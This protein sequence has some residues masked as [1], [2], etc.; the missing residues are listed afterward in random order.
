MKNRWAQ[1][2]VTGL[3]LGLAAL[4]VLTQPLSAPAEAPSA[5]P[6]RT[7]SHGLFNDLQVTRPLAEPTRVVLLL[8][9]TSGADAA[10]ATATAQAMTNAGAMVVR[11]DAPRFL[12]RLAGE[13]GSC[14]FADGALENL[15]H[16][17][18]AIFKLSSYIAPV[19]VGLGDNAALA[20]AV[21]A[22]SAPGTF[23]AAMSVGFCPKLA[24]KLPLCAG[25]GLRSTPSADGV[26][27]VLQPALRL[28]ASWAA[29]QA[30]T[31][32]ACN[33]RVA[34]P[35]VASA[36]H[37]QLVAV[38]S[39][40]EA[41]PAPWLPAFKT[42][43]ANLQIAPNVQAAPP[44]S[45]ADL[46]VI[47]VPTRVE[48]GDRFAVFLSG[49]GGWAG[50]DKDV[51]RAIAASG[52]PVAGFDSLR[53]FWTAR[54]P[55]GLADDLDRLIRYYAARWNR[56]RVMLIGYSQG[57]DVLPFAINRLPAATRA[58]I[59]ST[60]LLGLAQKASFEFRLGNWIGESGDKPVAPEAARLFASNTVCIHGSDEKN[61][62]CPSLAP[63][64]ARVLAMKG[65]H[66]FGGDYERLAAIILAQTATP[67]PAR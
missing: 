24:L 19:I 50:I 28:N 6:P 38:G 27:V 10:A 43:Y 55:Q 2:G 34:Q 57:A 47:E 18:E 53:Y 21:Q 32:P 4:P 31:D 66:H 67:A 40:A 16:H 60:V 41:D 3:L 49:D 29:L 20:Y 58:R 17:V 14:S 63:A 62:L 48:G 36:P 7:L 11:I 8:G 12:A 45:L 46:P 51:A 61:S 13:G 44:A 23:A 25:K 22:Q 59:Q 64:H 26:G 33:A 42:A 52:I 65:D 5:A 37:G 35:F 56:S 54:T 30:E 9:D 15:A 39:A 1:R